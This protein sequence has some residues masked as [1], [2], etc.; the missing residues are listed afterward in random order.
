MIIFKKDK[1]ARMREVFKGHSN[2]E[3]GK[4]HT[5]LVCDARLKLPP[6]KNKQASCK[7]V[8]TFSDVI[9][10]PAFRKDASKDSLVRFCRTDEC[11][12]AVSLSIEGRVLEPDVMHQARV[13]P[14]LSSL[15]IPYLLLCL[16]F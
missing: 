3:R 13:C 2:D 9:Q 12:H 4:E 8:C 10:G 7:D 14:T 16:Y 11:F 15:K 1:H 6:H 5:R